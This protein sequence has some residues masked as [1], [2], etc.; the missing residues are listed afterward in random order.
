MDVEVTPDADADVKRAIR[1][2]LT[3]HTYTAES[4]ERIR[5][6]GRN[7]WGVFTANGEWIEG[8]I[9]WADPTFCRWVA[10]GCAVE[11]GRKSAARV[12]RPPPADR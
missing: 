10:S 4:P 12:T 7:G 3:M 11:Q 9:R 2:P 5:L 8:P 6:E 1:H